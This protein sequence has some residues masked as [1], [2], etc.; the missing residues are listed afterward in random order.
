[1]YYLSSIPFLF[2]G[3][4]A[5]KPS[6]LPHTIIHPALHALI[7]DG[8]I[9]VKME[10]YPT[11]VDLV[12]DDDDE[13]EEKVNEETDVAISGPMA[14]GDGTG[15]M[16]SEGAGLEK[17][18]EEKESGGGGGGTLD[19]TLAPSPTSG[20]ATHPKPVGRASPHIFGILMV[21]L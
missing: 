19:L 8:T 12:E 6:A 3:R 15:S 21:G 1:M 2:S 13:K 5:D 11:V 14:V 7:A 20:E 9:S 10:F 4:A 16:T 18:V 17:M